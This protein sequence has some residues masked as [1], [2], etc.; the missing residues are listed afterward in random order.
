MTAINGNDRMINPLMP[1]FSITSSQSK[2]ASDNP[3]AISCSD[4]P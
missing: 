4:I 1:D 3:V 2:K